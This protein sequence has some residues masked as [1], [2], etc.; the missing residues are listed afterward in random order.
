MFSKNNTARFS[1]W[2]VILAAVILTFTTFNLARWNKSNIIIH[3][4]QSYYAYLPAAFIYKDLTFNYKFDQTT[5]S[6]VVANTW[7]LAT[8]EGKPVQKMSGGLSIVYAPFFLLSHGYAHISDHAANGYSLPYQKGIALS[9]LFYALLGMILMRST[10]LRFF[11][12]QA[13]GIAV[14]S[15]YIGTNLFYYITAE[16]AMSHNYSVFLI[17]LMVFLVTK[18][19]GAFKLFHSLAI[20]AILGLMAIVR[21][22]NALIALFPL[23]YWFSN[24][25]TTTTKNWKHWLLVFLGG[26]VGIAPQLLYW[27]YATGD[28]IY[29]S[30]NEEGFF[31]SDPALLKGLFSFRKGWLLY[32][33]LMLFS[34]VGFVPLFQKSK[35]LTMSVLPLLIIYLYVVFSWWCW[36]Y[37]GSFGM[38]SMID[39]YALLVFPL[40]SVV[41]WSLKRKSTVFR[42]L[43]PAILAVFI[44]LNQWQT[45]QYRKGLLHYDS[46]TA[47]TYQTIFFR[48]TYPTNYIE[49]IDPP[50]Y[51]Q[52][53]KGMNR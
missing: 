43:V 38:R 16:G 44:G 49:L 45:F 36:W 4:I 41:E 34:L 35:A 11:T 5:D 47:E 53:K 26:V 51:E 12:D 18:K 19:K 33:P 37:G 21:P 15:I 39:L 17:T 50:D 8:P 2:A 7:T 46:M 28:W 3:D 13:V 32:T 30:Y 1:T 25:E 42:Y 24:H 10:L 9:S 48:S 40:T 27:K 6:I 22:I 31:F 29:Y 20:G 14:F 23:I 52:A